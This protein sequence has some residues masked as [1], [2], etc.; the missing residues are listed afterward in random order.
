M[1]A[2]AAFGLW[3][4]ILPL[5]FWV[6]LFAV[7]TGLLGLST[8]RRMRK[9]LVA[10][11]RATRLPT[12]LVGI[13]LLVL[14]P[15][16]AGFLGGSFAFKRAVAKSID[17]GGEQLVGWSVTRGAASMQAALGISDAKKKLPARELRAMIEMQ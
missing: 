8:V 11:G 2:I 14:A 12:A 9:Q 10:S 6:P 3:N 1:Q 17:K 5:F 7:A 15:V 4:L 13:L 16:G